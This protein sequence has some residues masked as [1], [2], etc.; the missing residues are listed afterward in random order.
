MCR[1]YHGYDFVIDDE[2]YFL[3]QKSIG[4]WFLST[5]NQNLTPSEVKYKFLKNEDK[6]IIHSEMNEYWMT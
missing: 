5:D 3:S 4:K 2:K 6:L 1:H